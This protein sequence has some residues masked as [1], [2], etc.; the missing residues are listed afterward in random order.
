MSTYRLYI[1]KTL[2]GHK[3]AHSFLTLTR[4]RLKPRKCHKFA[5]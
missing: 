1:L 5:W 4:Q 3:D 2:E